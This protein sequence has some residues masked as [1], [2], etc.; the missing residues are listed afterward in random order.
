MDF[1]ANLLSLG[2]FASDVLPA[3]RE[4]RPGFHLEMIGYCPDSVREELTRPGLSFSGYA[5]DLPAKLRGFR[6]FVAPITTGTGVKTKTLD[7]M[8]VGLPVVATTLGVSG[9][10]VRDGTDYLLARDP[11]E[12]ATAIGLLSERP[13][14]AAEI[15]LAGRELV[16]GSFAP[17]VITSRWRKLIA[18]L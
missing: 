7:A 16:R 12:F 15:G 5:A 11:L 6:G 17:D 4:R 2:W 18:E 3:V 9:L 13:D 14:E 8:A 10:D 1:Q